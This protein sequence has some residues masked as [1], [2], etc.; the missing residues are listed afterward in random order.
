[1]ALSISSQVAKSTGDQL[2]SSGRFIL[3]LDLAGFSSLLAGQAATEVALE[4]PRQLSTARS[5]VRLSIAR[6]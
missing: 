4:Q 2:A 3:L 1:L 5:S 6:N